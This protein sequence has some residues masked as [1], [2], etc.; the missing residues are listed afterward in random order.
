MRISNIYTHGGVMLW[1]GNIAW[2]FAV[3]TK[4]A[5]EPWIQPS[6]FGIPFTGW[7]D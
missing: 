7:R 1:S 2:Y 3:L 5:I 6:E 4:V